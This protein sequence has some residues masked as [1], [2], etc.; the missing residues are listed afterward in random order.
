MARGQG[1]ASR[2]ARTQT[3]GPSGSASTA[4]GWIPAPRSCRRAPRPISRSTSASYEQPRGLMSRCRRFLTTLPS[5]TER[6]N[7]RTLAELAGDATPDG[8]QQL[9]NFHSWSADAVRDDLRGYVTAAMSD[10]GDATF[11]SLTLTCR[12]PMVG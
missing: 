8:M 5:G 1:V 4:Q 10:P 12:H 6:R 2:E 11:P 7:G 3:S 9:L